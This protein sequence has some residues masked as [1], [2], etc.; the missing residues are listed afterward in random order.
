MPAYVLAT[1]AVKD[2]EKLQVYLSQLPST[3]APFGGKLVC[4]GKVAKVLEG[5]AGFQIMAT[6]E[7]ADVETADAW[8]QSD[9]YQALI[10]NRDKA[11]EG[12]IVI[13]QSS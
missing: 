2:P 5:S 7:F 10:P 12:T 11:L 9:A 3:L 13:L 6:F 1:V 8:Y 4:R